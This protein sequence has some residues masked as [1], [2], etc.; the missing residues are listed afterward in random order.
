MSFTLYN[1]QKIKQT[2]EKQYC[3]IHGMHPIFTPTTKGYRLETCCTAFGDI[4]QN[5]VDRLIQ[6]EVNLNVE[7]HVKEHL[8]E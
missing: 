5:I 2:I 4:C 3:H 1:E 8:G 7:R 6:V